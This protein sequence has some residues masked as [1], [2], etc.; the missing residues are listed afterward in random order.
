V[1]GDV[2]LDDA[3]RAVQRKI[4]AVSVAALGSCSAPASWTVSIA[5]AASHGTSSFSTCA[6][7]SIAS[8]SA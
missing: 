3:A 2:A 6:A 8:A 7:T 5:C 4:A 1:Q